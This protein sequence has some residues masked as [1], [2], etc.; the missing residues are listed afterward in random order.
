[1]HCFLG[2]VHILCHPP[3]GGGSQPISDF[4]DKGRRGGL[5]ISDFSDKGGRAQLFQA[6]ATFCHC[7][8]SFKVKIQ[9]YHFFIGDG[10]TLMFI[11]LLGPNLGYS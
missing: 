2:A 6:G 10:A 8:T 3:W 9:I 5:P 7:L 4:S 11:S 1:M